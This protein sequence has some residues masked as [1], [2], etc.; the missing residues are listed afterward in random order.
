MYNQ[1]LHLRQLVYR[2][3]K[4][5]IKWA[6]LKNN[7][8]FVSF[9]NLFVDETQPLPEGWEVTRRADDSQVRNLYFT[10]I[11]IYFQ[12]FFIDHINH[13]IVL[14]DPRIAVSSASFVSN[15]KTSHVRSRSE[16]TKKSK[17]NVNLPFIFYILLEQQQCFMG[18]NQQK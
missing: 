14:L 9:L 7:K 15:R 8:E 5:Q 4:D 6:E 3:R 2:I 16:P 1:K 11:V 10:V 12:M 13:D 18:I 17:N